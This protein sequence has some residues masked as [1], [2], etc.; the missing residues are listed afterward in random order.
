MVGKSTKR[1]YSGGLSMLAE[2]KRCM[3][4]NRLRNIVSPL[5]PRNYP[6][7]RE[8]LLLFIFLP[9]SLCVCVSGMVK[10]CR[11]IKFIAC[12]SKRRQDKDGKKGGNL[13]NCRS[14][15]KTYA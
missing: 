11:N 15:T 5:T 7:M 2:T 1:N 12:T 3:M 10:Y 14:N 4:K 9:F 13:L 8:L 6:N